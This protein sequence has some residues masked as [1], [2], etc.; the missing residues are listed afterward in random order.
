LSENIY[1]ADLSMTGAD[2]GET[3]FRATFSRV[4]WDKP[5]K[6]LF[7]KAGDGKPKSCGYA[8]YRGLTLNIA[9]LLE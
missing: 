9:D 2:E 3:K 1:E 4:S 5:P 7:D 8:R 6:L